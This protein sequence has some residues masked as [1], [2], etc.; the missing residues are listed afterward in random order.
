[1]FLLHKPT[2]P[3]TVLLILT[4]VGGALCAGAAD[5]SSRRTG[6]TWIDWAADQAA[7]VVEEAA[8][9]TP[10]MPTSAPPKAEPSKSESSKEA[11]H[12]IESIEINRLR[13]EIELL[14]AVIEQGVIGRVL[15][16]ENEVRMLREAVYRQQGSEFIGSAPQ[17]MA[18]PTAPTAV[19]P[20]VP[21]GRVPMP[22]DLMPTPTPSPTPEMLAP[23]EAFRFTVVDEWGR[24]PEVAKDLGGDASTLIG[25]AGMVPARSAQDDVVALTQQL[26][27]EYKDYDNIS[28]EIFDSE[29]AAQDFAATQSVDPA[30]HVA[31]ISRHATSGRDVILYL[32]SGKAVPVP[33]PDE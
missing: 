19:P 32:G 22:D 28:I 8:A 1:M 25:I 33:L 4:G 23:A 5:P 6:V 30:H 15:I 27:S 12:S 31:S 26:R 17:T 14:R 18:L 21:V 7:F 9:A 20:I 24:S 29:R 2:R 3:L 11:T 16:L 13:E 10:P